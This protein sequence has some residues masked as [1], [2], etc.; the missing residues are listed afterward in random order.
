MLFANQ[1]VELLLTLSLSLLTLSLSLLALS[2]ELLLTLSF[3]LLTLSLELLLALA[4]QSFLALPLGCLALQLGLTL[5]LL[6][7]LLF[8][9][10]LEFA[11]TALLLGHSFSLLASLFMV[12]HLELALAA[13]LLGRS[14]GL[15]LRQQLGVGR[16]RCHWWRLS[17]CG[18]QLLLRA[19]LRGLALLLGLLPLGLL[20]LLLD[21]ELHA[22][23]L[24]GTVAQVL[25][26][27]SCKLALSLQLDLAH[28]LHVEL[29]HEQLL[30]LLLER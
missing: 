1:L 25:L 13:L 5:G 26:L 30:L 18:S 7:P 21:R 23:F 20:A 15:L 27:L 10:L 3:S 28:L 17:Q 24:L 11:L 22:A 4:Q 29:L 12:L 14:F 9:E 2:L 8:L 19:K 16:G 6:A